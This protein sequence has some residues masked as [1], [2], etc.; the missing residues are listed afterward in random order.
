[1]TSAPPRFERLDELAAGLPIVDEERVAQLRAEADERPI[2]YRFGSAEAEEV[3]L[4]AGLKPLVRQYLRDD[5]VAAA[6]DRFESLGLAVEV[7]ASTI[8][9]A[10]FPGRVLYVG[11]ERAR[12]R[13]AVVADT[14]S[15]EE[16]ALGR[17]LGYPRCCVAG[18]L[19]LLAPRRNVHL[20]RLALARTRGPGHPRL[21]L[22]DL[23]VFHYLSWVPCSYTCAAS[24]AYANA[25]AFQLAIL[26]GQALGRRGPG[27]RLACP[28]GCGHQRFVAR[29]D[30]ALG[31][32]RLVLF[33]DAQ[34]SIAGR[35]DGGRIAV[36]RVWP[37]TRDRHPQAP[38]DPSGREAVA[39][40]AARIEQARSL[41]VADDV[42]LL[43]DEPVLATPDL[44]L[45]PFS[46]PSRS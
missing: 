3:A 10:P 33:E 38:T 1:M 5:E 9:E 26:H 14:S 30:E 42:L 21:N 8:R 24:I 2:E 25:V 35:V 15:G 41:A 23:G 34:L 28:P 12:V 43:D 29:I 46:A 40:L 6:R 17:L 44:L 37:T 36:E 16:E 11:R 39:R 18:F 31:A 45:V 20:H 27:P 7:A 13:A 22:L 19:E 32:H 4:F